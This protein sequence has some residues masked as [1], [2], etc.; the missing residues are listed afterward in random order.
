MNTTQ[1]PVDLAKSVFEVA[2]SEEPGRVAARHRLSRA[3]FRSFF[4]AHGG[5][6][7]FMEACATAHYWARELEA[8]GH[9][10][11]LRAS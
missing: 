11:S 2:V 1:I 7:V 6:H 3:R 9:R 8:C 4:E 10:V 5:A